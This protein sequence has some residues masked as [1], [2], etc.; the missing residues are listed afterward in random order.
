MTSFPKPG[1]KW[2]VST[3]GGGFPRW[4]GDSREIFYHALDGTVTEAEVEPRAEGLVVRAAKPLFK[5]QLVSTFGYTYASTPDGRRFLV[6]EP[7]ENEA[8]RP[9]TVV[10]NWT[11]RP[12]R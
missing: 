5:T 11:A 8:P 3:Q 4:R 2:Q 6:I 1:R 12:K 7:V 10:L 9:L